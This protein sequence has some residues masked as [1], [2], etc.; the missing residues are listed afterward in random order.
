MSDIRQLR[1]DRNG[2]KRTPVRHHSHKPSNLSNMTK[3]GSDWG[4]PGSETGKIVERKIRK[5][6]PYQ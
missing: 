4:R 1:K 3:T 5:N 6:Q 2:P